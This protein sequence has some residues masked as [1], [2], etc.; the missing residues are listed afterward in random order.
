MLDTKARGALSRN[1]LISHHLRVMALVVD[2]RKGELVK[3]A[4]EIPVHPAT[5]SAWIAQGYV[6]YFQ[7]KKLLKRFGKKLVVM[8]ELCPEEFRNV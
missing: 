7:C 6:P 8:D 5:L 1:D 4:D 2:P 3:L